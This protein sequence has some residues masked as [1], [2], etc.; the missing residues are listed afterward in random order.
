MSADLAL[1]SNLLGYRGLKF[2]YPSSNQ[3]GC[4][5]LN[6][7][8]CTCESAGEKFACS[9]E[10]IDVKCYFI[11][12]NLYLSISGARSHIHESPGEIFCPAGTCVNSRD[13]HLAFLR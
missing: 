8:L 7:L 2:Y 3:S 9:S 11:D 1:V 10:R 13:K 12:E 6:F 4:Y 5:H